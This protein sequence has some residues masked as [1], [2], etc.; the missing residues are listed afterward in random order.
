MTR[1][2]PPNPFLVLLALSGG[3]AL[4]GAFGLLLSHGTWLD[5]VKGGGF[6]HDWGLGFAVVVGIG[7]LA[8]LL[9]L[10]QRVRR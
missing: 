3:V 10:W 8:A 9:L 4:L 5:M 2:T 7:A 1:P 6:L